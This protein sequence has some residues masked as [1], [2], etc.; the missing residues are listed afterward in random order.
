M[1]YST[2]NGSTEAMV[3]QNRSTTNSIFI[4]VP[5]RFHQGSGY[6]ENTLDACLQEEE[7]ARTLPFSVVA[8]RSDRIR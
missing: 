1:A 2:G 4:L 8:C 3:L 7:N 6:F 5:P